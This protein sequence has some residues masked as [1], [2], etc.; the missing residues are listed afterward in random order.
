MA[1]RLKPAYP[2]KKSGGVFLKGSE[3]KNPTFDDTYYYGKGQALVIS[4]NAGVNH[5]RGLR[6]KNSIFESAR[7][8]NPAHKRWMRDGK[9]IFRV[10]QMSD[11][12]F[13]RCDFRRGFWP[14]AKWINLGWLHGALREHCVYLDVDFAYGD[15]L[16]DECVFQDASSQ[17]LQ[18][19]GPWSRPYNAADPDLAKQGQGTAANAGTVLVNKCHFYRMPKH[20]WWA[21][22]G[23]S[24]PAT[25]IGLYR[26]TKGARYKVHDCFVKSG[27]FRGFKWSGG[28][29]NA[30]GAVVMEFAASAELIRTVFDVRWRQDRP[31]IQFERNASAVGRQNHLKRRGDVHFIDPVDAIWEDNTSEDPNSRVLHVYDQGGKKGKKVLGPVSGKYEWRGGVLV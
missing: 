26:S 27:Q 25:A 18:I 6:A 1:H 19:V 5:V 29:A 14:A 8:W 31:L 21:R 2:T 17:G 7:V 23:I 28:T 22:A 3:L 13:R 10:Y 12:E 20:D 9:W 16:F 15:I 11:A 30:H 4:P 24:R